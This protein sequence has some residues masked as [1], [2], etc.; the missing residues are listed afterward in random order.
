L[1]W[2]PSGKLGQ[3]SNGEKPF[4]GDPAPI[5]GRVKESNQRKAPW[6]GSKGRQGKKKHKNVNTSGTNGR[7]LAKGEKEAREK[8]MRS[9]G[10]KVTTIHRRLSEE[11]EQEGTCSK[12]GRKLSPQRNQRPRNLKVD[13]EEEIGT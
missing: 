3:A 7:R 13:D 9:K 2:K 1:W 10:T 6:W 5:G 8:Q 11:R 12:N 4:K